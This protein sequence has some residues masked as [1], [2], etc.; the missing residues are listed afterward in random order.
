M[1][2]RSGPI[3]RLADKPSSFSGRLAVNSAANPPRRNM[4]AQETPHHT[5]ATRLVAAI[6]ILCALGSRLKS[7]IDVRRDPSAFA[8]RQ[9]PQCREQL[10][11]QEPDVRHRRAALRG[12]RPAG[13]VHARGLRG[14]HDRRRSGA[15]CRG[16]AGTAVARVHDR[17]R[18]R[19]VHGERNLLSPGG[20]GRTRKPGSA[21]RRRRAR[22]YGDHAFLRAHGDE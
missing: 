22:L 2:P 5:V 14:V 16:T 11:Q 13:G 3:R 18:R 9:R 20:V 1:Q 6:R 12:L 17:A 19:N 10:R 15:L 7:E 21:D 8:W 4:Q